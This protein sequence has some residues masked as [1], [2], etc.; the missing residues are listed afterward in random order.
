MQKLEFNH[1][2]VDVLNT[3]PYME[4]LMNHFLKKDFIHKHLFPIH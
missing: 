2:L 3:I 4:Y 1:S